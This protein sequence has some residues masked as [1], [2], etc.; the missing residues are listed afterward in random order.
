LQEIVFRD[1]PGIVTG[2]I[3]TIERVVDRRIDARVLECH[4]CPQGAEKRIDCLACNLLLLFQIPP[5]RRLAGQGLFPHV[6]SERIRTEEFLSD[7]D[8]GRRR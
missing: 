6:P 1:L 5:L 7:A 2:L 8:D 3:K 4:L